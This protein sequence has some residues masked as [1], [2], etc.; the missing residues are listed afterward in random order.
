MLTPN[1]FPQA[2]HC[3]ILCRQESTLSSTHGVEVKDIFY[4]L[5][6]NGD[7]GIFEA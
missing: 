5:F 2:L 1:L 3:L 7:F 6:E 4:F